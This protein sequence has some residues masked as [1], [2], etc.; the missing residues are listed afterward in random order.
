M[1]D[2]NDARFV[3][4][5]ARA[6]SLT[7]AARTLRVDHSTVFRRLAALE[8]RFG[9]PLFERTPGGTYQPT[10]AGRRTAL[11]AERMEDEVLA[12]G[13]D[14]TGQDAR[15]TGRL[16][17]TCS[18][19]LA[20][21]LLTQLVA[22]FRSKHP[23]IVVELIVDSRLLSLSRREADVAL[24]AT[25]PREGDLW[26]RKLADVAWTAYGAVDYL[27]AQSPLR[28]TADLADHSLIGWEEGTV[29]INA[30]DWLAA[31]APAAAIV[32]RSN[33]LIN[34]LVA[35]R[36]GIG[37]AV[38]PCYLGDTVSGLARALS[39]GPLP[40]LARELW[41]VT[42]QDLRRT[43]RIRVFFDAVAIGIEADRTRIE[44]LEPDRYQGSSLP[45]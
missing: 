11:A 22:K 38:L 7:A 28:T 9:L 26:G 43:A 16:R 40:A 12:L 29:G 44:G 21:S 5:I 2:W 20:F 19:T 37:L 3:L 10:A 41:I 35:A 30:A 6:G 36:A 8:V 33:S 13:R 39:N 17:V 18:E 24:R 27:A 25:R 31:L 45:V 42:H 4:A 14:L 23:G 32:Y 1:D 34:Q 15:L